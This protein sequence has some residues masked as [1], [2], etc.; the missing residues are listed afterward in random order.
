VIAI[1]SAL[2]VLSNTVTRGI[3]SAVRQVGAVTLI[4]TDAAINPGNSGGPLVDRAGLVIGV[5]SIG[6][7]AAQGLA[8]AVAIE[9]ARQLLNGQAAAS[10]QTPLSALQ[11]ATDGPAA[12][13]QLR[14]RGEQEYAR[15][16]QS[17]ARHGD[18]LDTYWSRYSAACVSSSSR[19]GDRPWFAVYEPHGVRI[20]ATSQYNCTSWLDTLH[21][22]AGEIR[23]ALDAAAEAARQSGVYPG[24][25]RDIRRRH[26]MEWRGWDR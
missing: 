5:N 2:G 26:R 16:V 6:H 3:V 10:A 12:A 8:F 21:K 20:T 7:R 18:S 11:Q 14:D 1:G 24:V 13:E 22:N 9:H 19:S 23:A 15:E 17:A 25:M 4:Q